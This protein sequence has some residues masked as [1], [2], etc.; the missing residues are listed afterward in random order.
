MPHQA[1]D[2]TF[3][4]LLSILHH[5]DKQRGDRMALYKFLVNDNVVEDVQWLRSQREMFEGRVVPK[6]RPRARPKGKG[7]AK[8]K[9]AVKKR[10]AKKA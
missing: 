5:N 1:E 10:P 2:R 8:A 3:D 7:K 4:L 6:A 9:A